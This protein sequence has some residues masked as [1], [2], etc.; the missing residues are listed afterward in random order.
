MIQT[1]GGKNLISSQKE[2]SRKMELDE[3]KKMNP[4]II[5]MMPCGFDVD[6]TIKEY[7]KILAQD[8]E[9]SGLKA[10]REDLVFAVDANSYFS[11]PSFR[12]IT[13]IEIL[14]KI[15]HPEIFGNMETPENSFKKIN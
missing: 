8:K 6:R 3:L 11:K 1:A 12:T 5:I 14:A 4:D 7:D 15:I 9:W 13:G 2:S 10:V